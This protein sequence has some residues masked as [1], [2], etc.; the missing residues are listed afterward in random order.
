MLG[1]AVG[2]AVINAV[3]E[4][5]LSKAANLLKSHAVPTENVEVLRK[6]HPSRGVPVCPPA[7]TGLTGGPSGQRPCHLSE[8]LK[9][10][11]DES[12][13]SAL[14]DFVSDFNSDFMP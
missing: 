9:S 8:M 1:A 13:A 3:S 2:R 10:G 4:G 12:L 5:S 6:L 7:R 11:K 14:T